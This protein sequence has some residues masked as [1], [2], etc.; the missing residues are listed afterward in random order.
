MEV[1]GRHLAADAQRGEPLRQQVD[2]AVLAF[3][4][5]LDDQG[6]GVEGDLALTLGAG[7]VWRAGEEFLE[8][9]K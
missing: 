1:A 7:N 4:H 3:E 5:P 9:M 8:G 2:G 6:A